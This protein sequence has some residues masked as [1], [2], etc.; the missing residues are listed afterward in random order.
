MKKKAL[1]SEIQSKHSYLCVGLDTDPQQIPPQLKN[2]KDSVFTFN[3]AIIDATQAYSVAYKLNIAFYESLGARGWESLE[4]TLNYMPN[5]CLTIADA[6]RSDIGNTAAKYAQTFFDSYNFDAVTL[7]PLMG[8]D[9]VEPFLEYKNKWVILLV[10]TSNHGAEDF[11]LQRVGD[12]YLYELILKKGQNW[13]SHD[14]GMFVI[15]ATRPEKF[16]EIRALC[17]HH[18]FLVPGIGKQ[19]GSIETISKAGMTNDVV[20]TADETIC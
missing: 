8:K 3:K 2:E 19:G 4:K 1:V 15:G 9:S 12:Q 17:P 18:F 13:V 14:Q 11:Q 20:C 16:K 6:K 5:D 7:N 10:L